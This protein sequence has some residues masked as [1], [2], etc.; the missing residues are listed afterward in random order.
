MNSA[1]ERL[2]GLRVAD[3]MSRRVVTVSQ[4]QTLDEASRLLTEN[5]ISGLPV[6][7]EFGRCVGVL[8]ASDFV[9]HRQPRAT[10]SGLDAQAHL[11]RQASPE[12]PLS[13]DSESSEVVSRCMSR[14]VQ[15][16]EGD[17]PLLSAARMMCAEHIHRLPVVDAQG[18]PTGV[19]TSLDIVAALVGA[20]EE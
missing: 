15:P 13:I 9:R 17:A 2:L 14:G 4:S 16:I 20:I 1:I 12:G 10:A 6:V 5:Q 19:I 8:S 11:V 18:R 3:V 7:D